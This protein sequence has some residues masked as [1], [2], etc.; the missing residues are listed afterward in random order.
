MNGSILYRGVLLVRHAWRHLYPA[1]V[2]V[3]VVA[4]LGCATAGA[5]WLASF[6]LVASEHHN[7]LHAGLWDWWDAASAWHDGRLPKAGRKIAGAAV[8][9]CLMA[10]GGP[11]FAWWAIRN[12]S[13]RRELHGSAQFA[14]EADIRRAG[15]L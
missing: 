13:G 4:A 11:L 3:A 2:T 6:L 10:F 8:L 9:G 1:L 12:G 15:L 7:P 14:T 5:F